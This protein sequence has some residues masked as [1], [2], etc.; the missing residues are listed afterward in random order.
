MPRRTL[1]FLPG[2]ARRGA[3]RKQRFAKGTGMS[4]LANPDKN[5]GAQEASGIRVAFSLDT[6]FC[7]K[8]LL[9][10]P[11]S[12][13]PCGLAKQKKVSRLRVREPD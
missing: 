4:L 6:F 8:L 2:T 3:A 11:H 9:R 13:H 5:D 10:F 1:A 12:P 7:G